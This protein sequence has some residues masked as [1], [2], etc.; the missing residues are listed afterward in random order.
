MHEHRIA[1]VEVGTDGSAAEPGQQLPQGLH[2]DALLAADVD[3]AQERYVRCHV[4][5]VV[6]FEKAARPDLS[7]VP[8]AA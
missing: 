4:G 2:G 8:A 5:T 7:R 1:A 6:A 3:T